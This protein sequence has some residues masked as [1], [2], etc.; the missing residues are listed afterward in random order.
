MQRRTRFKIKIHLKIKLH[1][2]FFVCKGCFRFVL[3]W[4]LFCLQQQKGSKTTKKTS[5]LSKEKIKKQ[6]ID[7][8]IN[9]DI[10]ETG[11]LD[12]KA[13]KAEKLEDAAIIIKQYQDIIRT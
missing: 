13:D 6:L 11:E 2:A 10:I 12:E 1:I 4:L 5:R 8:I 9:N 7:S 3:Q